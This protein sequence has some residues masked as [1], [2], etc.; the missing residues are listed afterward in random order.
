R[1]DS[2][3]YDR[4]FIEEDR[5]PVAREGDEQLHDISYHLHVIS[6]KRKSLRQ[7][8][9]QR[10]ALYDFRRFLAANRPGFL[11]AMA[12]RTHRVTNAEMIER[13]IHQ[14]SVDS[15]TALASILSPN[16]PENLRF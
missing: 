1:V 8:N 5:L 4:G 6:L 9:N 16:F 15:V 2:A 12:S 14:E 11:E 7:Y 3:E 13:E 10:R